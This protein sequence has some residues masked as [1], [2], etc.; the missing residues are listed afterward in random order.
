MQIRCTL[1]NNYDGAIAK[2]EIDSVAPEQ[3]KAWF[4][5]LGVNASTAQ[6]VLSQSSTEPE[7]YAWFQDALFLPEGSLYYA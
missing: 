3:V 2:S 6:T 7:V 1:E 5:T 4:V